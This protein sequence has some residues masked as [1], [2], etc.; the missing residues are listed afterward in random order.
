MANLTKEELMAKVAELETELENEKSKSLNMKTRVMTLLDEGVNSI[1]M[2]ATELNVSNKNV[3]SVLT[4]LR[5][6]LRSENKT[7]ITQQHEG[8]TMI[9]VLDLAVLGWNK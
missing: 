5:K 4:A 1:D 2:L 7:I 3:S 8:S 6:E 9:A